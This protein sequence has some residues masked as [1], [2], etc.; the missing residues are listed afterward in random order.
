[1]TLEQDNPLNWM[2]QD[3]TNNSEFVLQFIELLNI[4]ETE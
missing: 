2:R 4:S 1:V 3:K